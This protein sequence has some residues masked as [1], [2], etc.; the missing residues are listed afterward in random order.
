MTALGSDVNDDRPSR[1]RM[2]VHSDAV[3]M[4]INIGQPGIRLAAD[5]QCR[6]RHTDVREITKLVTSGTLCCAAQLPPCPTAVTTVQP[7]APRHP[8]PTPSPTQQPSPA[9]RP[10]P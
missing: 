8:W 10:A 6:V 2:H 5:N 4:V 1:T 9:L 7:R 3:A